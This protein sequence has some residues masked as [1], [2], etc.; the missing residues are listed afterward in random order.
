MDETRPRARSDARLVGVHVLLDDLLLVHLRLHLFLDLLQGQV[1]NGLFAVEDTS[2]LLQGRALGLDVEEVDEDKLAE[3]PQLAVRVSS[4]RQ[5]GEVQKG[6]YSVEQHEVP[7]VGQALPGEQVGLVADGEDGLNDNVHDHHALGTQLE[8]ENLESVGDKQTG[9]ANIVK[10]SKEPDEGQLG[11]TGSVVGAVR[12]LV[13]GADDGPDHKG[14]AH[15]T[16]R[17]EEQGPTSILIN[18]HGG[19]DRHGKVQDGFARRDLFTGGQSAA[20]H[21]QVEGEEGRVRQASRS[22]S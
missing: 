20:G 4:A 2:D 8:W 10:D 12:V 17:D 13:D 11:N 6:T 1:G 16:G 5:G 21:A 18:R 15:A 9:E 14:H 7:V 22:G 19:P 3:V